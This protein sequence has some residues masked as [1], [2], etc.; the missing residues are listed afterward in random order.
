[1]RMPDD[2]FAFQLPSRSRE[3][4]TVG[5]RTAWREA[6]TELRLAYTAWVDAGP[7]GRDAFDAYLEAF[8]REAQAAEQLARHAAVTP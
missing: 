5:L 1:M 8:E 4:Y 3:A 7:T 2:P 6:C